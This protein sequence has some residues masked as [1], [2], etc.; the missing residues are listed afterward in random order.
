MFIFSRS[1]QFRVRVSSCFRRASSGPFNRVAYSQFAKLA[2]YPQRP[3]RQ[4]VC[5]VE[6]EDPH[7]YLKGVYFPINIR[8]TFKDGRYLVLQKLGWGGYATVWLAR[9]KLCVYYTTLAYAS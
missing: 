6:A 1:L 8:N 9:D 3:R 2:T 5:K 7:N 4:Y